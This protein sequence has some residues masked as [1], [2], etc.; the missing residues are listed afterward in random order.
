M[1]TSVHKQKNDVE[2]M[3]L[4]VSIAGKA[5]VGGIVYNNNFNNTVSASISGTHLIYP[6][7]K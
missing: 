2:S 4:A 3:N 5:S 1:S 7:M 6:L